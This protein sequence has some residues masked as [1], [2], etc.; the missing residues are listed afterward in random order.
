MYSLCED[1]LSSL[2]MCYILQSLLNDKS[3]GFKLYS[4]F[5]LLYFM[6][7]I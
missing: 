5:E 3:N 6:D 2:K 1:V 7:T 4:D